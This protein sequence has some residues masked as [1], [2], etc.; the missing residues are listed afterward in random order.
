[1]KDVMK[2][3]EY[4]HA[5]AKSYADELGNYT[6]IFTSLI[7]SQNYG[8]DNEN[9]DCDTFSIVLPTYMDFISGKEPISKEIEVSDGKVVIKDF[10][11]AMNNLRKSTPNSIEVFSSHYVVFEPEYKEIQDE[12][13]TPES[14]AFLIRA[15]YTSMAKSILGTVMQLHGRNMTEGKRCAHALR[16]YDMYVQYF[17]DDKGDVLGFIFKGTRDMARAAKFFGSSE[18]DEQ[19]YHDTIEN[20]QN[21]LKYRA[22]FFKPSTFQKATEYLANHSIN[23]LQFEVMKIYLAQ[24][25]FTYKEQY[26]I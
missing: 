5:L 4:H 26:G 20:I 13:F 25:N 21:G 3:V 14:M 11:L 8:L 18:E 2:A 9:S 1:M 16:L 7:G 6:V 24:N 10:R 19:F 22:D 17:D 23:R 12:F 15:N